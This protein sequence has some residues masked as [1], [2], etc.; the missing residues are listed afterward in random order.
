MYDLPMPTSGCTQK[1]YPNPLA[2][3]YPALSPWHQQR[4]PIRH[5]ASG[6]GRS[7]TSP[8]RTSG[9]VAG[10]SGPTGVTPGVATVPN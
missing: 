1:V 10:V 7:P 3:P 6:A 2:H 4:V 5:D 9:L 8:G